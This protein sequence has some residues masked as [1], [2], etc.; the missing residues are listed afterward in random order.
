[1]ARYFD[2][3][4]ALL[5]FEAP[6]FE[7]HGLHAEF[8][9]HPV[10]ERARRMTGGDG[11]SRPARHRRRERRCWRASGQPDERSPIADAGVPRRGGAAGAR[12]AG[13]RL[14][15]ADRAPCC[16]APC[17]ARAM[18]WPAPLH[19]VEQEADKFAAFDAADA[20][21]AASGTVTTELALARHADGGRLQGRLA[22][23]CAGDWPHYRALCDLVNIILEREAM[24]EFMQDA[25]HGRT[26]SPTHVRPLLSDTPDAPRT[27]ASDER[28]RGEAW[29][30]AKN[31]ILRAAR[32]CC[33]LSKQAQASIRGRGPSM[34]DR[35]GAGFASADHGA[36][37]CA[38]FKKAPFSAMLP[39]RHRQHSRAR[40]GPV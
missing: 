3:V 15:A 40:V 2:L 29:A 12:S 9:G 14:R 19:I 36:A 11:L 10:I 37:R 6:F 21:L 32:V 31:T 38:P 5:P 4:L 20:A 28:N 27:V 26:A 18:D 8:V 17:A 39:L 30:T 24:P 22:D 35:I 1:M 25:V 7:K 13:S 16:R 34:R 23:L 33:G